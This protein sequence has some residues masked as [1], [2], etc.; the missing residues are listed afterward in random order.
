MALMAA[1]AALA[2]QIVQYGVA[3]DRGALQKIQHEILV[4]ALDDDFQFFHFAVLQ[5][6]H[7]SLPPIGSR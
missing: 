7:L 4:F 1:V 3:A 6:L 5:L 2:R